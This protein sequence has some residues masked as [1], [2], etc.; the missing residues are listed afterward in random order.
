MIDFSMGNL[1][2]SM[3]NTDFSMALVGT[4][5]GPMLERGGGYAA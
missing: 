3:K 5:L 2:F 4:A 1:D